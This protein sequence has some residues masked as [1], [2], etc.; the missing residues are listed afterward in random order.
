MIICGDFNINLFLSDK[1]TLIYQNTVALNGF[2]ILNSLSK[3]F[4]TRVNK[5]NKTETCIDHIWSDLHLSHQ[6]LRH[7]L[8]LFDLLGDHKTFLLNI[9]SKLKRINNKR[10]NDK[11]IILTNHQQIRSQKLIQNISAS[12]FSEYLRAIQNIISQNSYS[13]KPH[14]YSKPYLTTEIIALMTI[15]DNYLK[16]KIKFPQNQ[17]ACTNYRKFRNKVTNLLKTE[18]KKYYDYFFRDNVNNPRQTWSKLKSLLFNKSESIQQSCDMIVEQGIPITNEQL[19]ATRFNKHFAETPLELTSKIVCDGNERRIHLDNEAYEIKI[20]FTSP[21]VTE[22]EITLVINNLSN[23]KACDFYG[24]STHFVKTHIAEITPKLTSLISNC[25]RSGNFEDSLKVALVTPVFKGSSKYDKSNYRPISVLPIFAKILEYVILRRLE[26]YFYINKIFNSNQFGYTRKSSTESAMIHTLKSVYEG[27]DN[28]NAVALTAIDL[29]KAFDC[30]DHK[31]LLTKLKKLQLP[32]TFFNLIESYFTN[33]T[34]HVRIGTSISPAEKMLC[35]TPQ[36]GVL[37]GFFF[38][39]FT[40]SIAKLNLHSNL[41]MYADDIS[42]ITCSPDPNTLKLDIE[43]DLESLNQ[44][45][46]THR[47]IPNAKKTKYIMFHN[48][49]KFEPFTVSSLNIKFDNVVLERVESIKILGL[50]IDERLNFNKHVEQINNNCIPF[51]FA[52]RRLRPF[53]TERTALE[54]YYAYIHSRLAYMISLWAT[55]P[56]YTVESVEILQRKALRIVY[57]KDRTCRSNELYSE[58]I[59]PMSKFSEFHTVVLILKMNNNLLKNNH[60]FL[61]RCEIQNYV[62]RGAKDFIV[63]LCSTVLAG[64]N[65]FIRG[66]KLFNELPDAIKR[67]NSINIFKKRLSEF[68]FNKLTN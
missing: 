26:D 57:R 14:K 42:L 11:P 21:T 46:K 22:D 30:V 17:Y 59:L 33:R 1:D 37:S 5:N 3:Q 32:E 53:I 10:S 8:F 50:V 62:T 41:Y 47:L 67:Y 56:K 55:A 23:S 9:E 6:D 63:P 38:N 7:N 52:F 27:L 65:F 49:K 18:K 60:P 16:L 4:P 24:I 28:R 66:P 29:S 61:R 48:R 68:L 51:I 36:G 39:F 2:T 31:I 19:I 43:S 20:P 15:R 58:K 44:W 54:M 13:I 35:G 45:L 12:N 25:L 34:Q 64:N 40:C